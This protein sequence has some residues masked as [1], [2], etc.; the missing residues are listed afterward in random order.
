M[1]VRSARVGVLNCNS[2]TSPK[3]SQL[4]RSRALWR[5]PFVR[6][7]PLGPGLRS[8]LTNAG[9]ATV[10]RAINSVPRSKLVV[11][12][13]KTTETKEKTKGVFAW[14]TAWAEANP[15]LSI[16]VATCVIASFGDMLCQLAIEK[17]NNYDLIRT[18]RM[19]GLSF[20][21]TGPTLFTWYGFLYR[22]FPGRD[23]TMVIKRL[24]CDQAL[25]A[26]FFTGTFISAL[27]VLQGNGSEIANHMEANYVDT[28]LVNW[29]LWI[30]AQLINFSIIPAQH[31]VI[32]ANCVA[33]IWNSYLS[34][35]LHQEVHDDDDV[36]DATETK[37]V[38]TTNA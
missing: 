12:R 32:F 38:E 4:C 2:F 19:G 33:V 36:D 27:F 28:L 3:V 21:L 29:G 10:R 24:V 18:L 6:V 30:P 23:L 11:S 13:F 5:A 9:G 8:Y 20:V 7:H 1:F 26:P 14:Y 17:T 15:L 37:I 22:K 35:K 34:W 16:S 25:F 31:A